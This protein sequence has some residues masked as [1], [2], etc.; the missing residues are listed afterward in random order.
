MY[1]LFLFIGIS[2]I[3]LKLTITEKINSVTLSFWPITLTKI[4]NLKKHVSHA[5]NKER[6]MTNK[7]KKRGLPPILFP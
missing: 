5:K 3:C 2:S 4:E 7:Q 1:N 6:K